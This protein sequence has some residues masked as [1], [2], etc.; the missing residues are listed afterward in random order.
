MPCETYAVTASRAC[1]L[2]TFQACDT[3]NIVLRIANVRRHLFR[4]SHQLK[5]GHHLGVSP[6][7]NQPALDACFV[8]VDDRLNSFI[9]FVFF[10]FFQ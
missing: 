9:G 7:A 10:R 4:L 6:Q 2:P 3:Q 5:A 8:F 1:Q